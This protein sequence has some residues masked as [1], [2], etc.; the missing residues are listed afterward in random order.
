MSNV[1]AEDLAEQEFQRF[2]DAMDLDIDPKGMDDDDR[3]AFK[4]A[5]RRFIQ[6]MM[7]G[8]LVVDEKGQPIYTPSGNGA[9]NEDLKPITF[10]EPSGAS[11]MA[12]DSKK[13]DHSVEKT[14][15]FMA[16]QT[17]ESPSRF[18]K[19]PNRDLKICMAVSGLFLD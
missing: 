16:D 7:I 14:M 2:A 17:G 5:K 18:A 1:V 4:H 6:S 10:R 15:A 9:P 13:K 3:A 8:K 19:M 11:L 12:M